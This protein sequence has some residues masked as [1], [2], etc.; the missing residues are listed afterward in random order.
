MIYCWEKP[1]NSMKYRAQQDQ[2]TASHVTPFLQLIFSGKWQLFMNK[3]TDTTI[4]RLSRSVSYKI[5]ENV[6]PKETNNSMIRMKQTW[7]PLSGVLGI[8]GLSS[9][10]S[11]FWQYCPHWIVSCKKYFG[12]EYLAARLEHEISALE[13][14][15]YAN[16]MIVLARGARRRPVWANITQIQM[17]SASVLIKIILRS[18]L[19]YSRGALSPRKSFAWD[20]MR[21]FPTIFLIWRR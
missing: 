12:K 1:F 4:K 5:L 2:N 10:F 14:P 20:V 16:H 17:N 19:G 8:A 15:V 21:H 3:H 18:R 9:V 6:R 13:S 7:F 11:R